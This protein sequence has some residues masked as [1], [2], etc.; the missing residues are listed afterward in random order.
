MTLIH[1]SQ[2][3]PEHENA[4]RVRPTDR[5][6][7][8]IIHQPSDLNCT[9]HRQKP[10]FIKQSLTQQPKHHQQQ[11][12]STTPPPPTQPIEPTKPRAQLYRSNVAPS[13]SHPVHPSFAL[14]GAHKTQEVK[15][16]IRPVGSRVGKSRRWDAW[17]VCRL[18]GLV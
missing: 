7:T 2:E 3:L 13:P 18:S 8:P 4:S 10:T 5:Y 17:R 1:G 6:Q 9:T 14:S 12:P 15:S 11:T 16:S